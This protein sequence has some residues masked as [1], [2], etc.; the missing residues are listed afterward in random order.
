MASEHEWMNQ[1]FPCP[2][3]LKLKKELGNGVRRAELTFF[4]FK[5]PK[6]AVKPT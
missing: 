1:D 6:K 4:F 3:F 2:S 5:Y